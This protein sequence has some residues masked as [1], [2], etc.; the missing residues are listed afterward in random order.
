MQPLPGSFPGVPKVPTSPIIQHEAEVA[1]VGVTSR[2]GY[3]EDYGARRPS[4][5]RR[6][7]CR[8]TRTA[9][10]GTLRPDQ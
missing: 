8:R 1:K 5:L 4:E 2:L 6:G 9:G 3:H 7:A 10:D